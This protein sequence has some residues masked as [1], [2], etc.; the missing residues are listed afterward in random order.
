MKIIY[1]SSL[2]ETHSKDLNLLLVTKNGLRIF[3]QFHTRIQ[4]TIEPYLSK[5]V[6]LDRPIDNFEIV[7]VKWPI[8][9][10][11]KKNVG[12]VGLLMDKSSTVASTQQSRKMIT[13]FLD[14]NC[15]LMVESNDHITKD[16]IPFKT[17]YFYSVN[18]LKTTIN[19]ESGKQLMENAGIIKISAD[20]YY[21]D[22]EISKIPEKSLVS[23]STASL[24]DLPKNGVLINKEFLFNGKTG[25][26]A[27][28]SLPDIIRQVYLPASHYVFLTS[29]SL[30][31]V[32]K[33]RP[34]D[35]LFQILH[36]S[37]PEAPID[38]YFA[39]INQNDRN[40][41]LP[42]TENKKSVKCLKASE[43]II[44]KAVL[45][46]FKLGDSIPLTKNESGERRDF[47]EAYGKVI[48]PERK[49]Y[50]FKIEAFILYFS[51]LIRPVW[52][53]KLVEKSVFECLI[54]DRL[55]NFSEEELQLVRKRILEIKNFINSKNEKL[56]IRNVQN[57]EEKRKS[58]RKN[59]LEFS[60]RNTGPLDKQENSGSQNKIKGNLEEII[61]DEKVFIKKK[62]FFNFY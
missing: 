54:Y 18:P 61:W 9:L 16:E 50:T 19:E 25:S 34:I 22:L 59:I 10:A 42:N 11:N 36:I 14:K 45:A 6:S 29:E 57:F 41:L 15:C 5:F 44:K 47:Y 8:I 3:I 56:L 7:F 28:N 12:H 48:Q 52:N 30:D 58:E 60:N 53:K 35:F 23:S 37:P 40:R 24:L 43:E 2:D 27:Y 13:G 32:L 26:L 4:S 31:F 39:R 62:L 17:I 38:E 33:A 46:F 51:R 55:E 20:H 1:I 49:K 21:D